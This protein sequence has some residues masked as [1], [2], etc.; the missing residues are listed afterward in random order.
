MRVEHDA[1]AQKHPNSFQVDIHY[2]TTAKVQR[3]VALLYHYRNSANKTASYTIDLEVKDP[4][5]DSV[6]SSLRTT[7]V[8]RHPHVHSQP[9]AH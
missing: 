3:S 6:L 7:G 9:F 5:L 2:A 4:S 8:P 1:F